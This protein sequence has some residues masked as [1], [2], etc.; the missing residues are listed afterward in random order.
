MGLSITPLEILTLSYIRKKLDLAIFQM[1]RWNMW[2]AEYED[3]ECE[4]CG[5]WKVWSENNGRQTKPEK[6]TH[7][8]TQ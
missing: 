2:S 4:K 8:N 1:V 6:T 3:E 7:H 5:V